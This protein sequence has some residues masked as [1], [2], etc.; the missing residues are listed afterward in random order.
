M[1]LLSSFLGN[2]LAGALRIDNTRRSPNSS[3]RGLH[4][5]QDGSKVSYCHPLF[6]YLIIYKHLREGVG[7]R[8]NSLGC[9]LHD[10]MG[11]RH[12]HKSYVTLKFEVYRLE[13]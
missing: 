12:R 3:R 1:D 13:R 11:D 2:F 10:L 6:K 9:A 5:L 4:K 7:L 8:I